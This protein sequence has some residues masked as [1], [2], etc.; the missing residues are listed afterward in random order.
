MKDLWKS[1]FVFDLID[2]FQ[3]ISNNANSNQLTDEAFELFCTKYVSYSQGR[4]SS[5]L[6][7]INSNQNLFRCTL[8]D[9][10]WSFSVALNTV[11]YYDEV[12]L[13]DPVIKLLNNTNY[14]IEGK[15]KELLNILNFFSNYKESIE[16][17]Y[18]L[19]VGN[20]HG[21]NQT[22]FYKE[23]SLELL[24]SPEVLAAFERL[25]PMGKKSSPINDN[26]EDN[27]TQLLAQYHGHWMESQPMSMYIPPHVMNSPSKLSKGVF[28]DFVSPFQP[29][30]KRGGAKTWK[31]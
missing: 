22:D 6:Y 16:G 26:E 21:S 20:S 25:T 19:F 17:G 29:P 12:I 9:S 14:Q 18:I 3:I 31:G 10:K 13:I 24:K 23:E 28:Y 11:W 8:P 4:D 7:Y 30:Y 15:K 5:L 2:E 1:G 27:L